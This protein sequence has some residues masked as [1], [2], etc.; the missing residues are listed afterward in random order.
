LPVSHSP[1]CR[2]FTERYDRAELIADA[3]MHAEGF[4]SHIWVAAAHARTRSKNYAYQNWKAHRSG[5][6]RPGYLDNPA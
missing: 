4:E 3:V 2:P 5:A 1:A 6:L